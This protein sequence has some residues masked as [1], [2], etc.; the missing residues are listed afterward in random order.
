MTS[1]LEQDLTHLLQEAVARTRL[2]PEG[3]LPEIYL[4]LPKERA[5]GD[6]AATTALKLARQAKRAPAEVARL[7]TQE[8]ETLLPRTA[9][10][11]SLERVEIKGP[12]F[13]NFF[14]SRASLYDVL[15][16]IREEGPRYGSAQV[17]AGSSV[18]VEF[19]SANPTGPLSI[20]HGR[21]AAVGD[22][23]AR[24]FAFQGYTVC[25][26]YY[27]ND[28][29]RQIN[30][31]GQS[32]LARYRERLGQPTPIPD[33]GYRGAY[34]AEIAQALV[35]RDGRK[36]LT[37]DGAA[38]ACSR[39]GVETILATIRKD[40]QDFGVSFERW[41]SEASLHQL[42]LVEQVLKVLRERQCLYEQE[43]AWWLASTKF[44]DDKDRVVRK[45]TGELTYLAPDIA[46][47]QDKFNRG[48]R[49]VINLWGPDHHGYIARLKAAMTALGY[50]ANDLAIIIVQ[51]VTLYRDGTP[52]QMSTRAGE[53]VTLRELIDEVGCD[54]ARFFLLMRK[55]DS[56]LDFDLVLAKRQSPD[57]PV[58]YVQYAHARIWSIV[59]YQQSQSG[60]GRA[61]A[62]V[63]YALLTATEELELLRVLRLFPLVVSACV[64]QIE[65]YGLTAYLRELA[66]AF[67][68]FYTKHRVVTEEAELSSARLALIDGVRQV[69][70][71]GLQLLGVSAPQKM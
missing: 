14:L 10:A 71:N 54:A 27:L 29:G 55:T 33:E 21:Q 25:R 66:A 64:R 1:T 19:V 17:G 43:G 58:Y 4:E 47:H 30:L 36:W 9:L 65:P 57:N 15:A 28:A 56:H 42:G 23:L 7:I 26:E 38:A 16:R 13:I 48:H 70:A 61:G 11:G 35:D 67:H 50:D 53:F 46:Y 41:V 6:M 44:G 69:L 2:V 12:G 32:I 52:V 62:E 3:E 34:I 18:S 22:A 60:G 37:D 39:Y 45:S 40:L 59:G 51:L 20:A 68:F 49:R 8:F 63:N 24:L 5:H 31:L